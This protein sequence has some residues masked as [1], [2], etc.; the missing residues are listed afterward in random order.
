MKKFG[1]FISICIAGMFAALIIFVIAV[2]YHGIADFIYTGSIPIT[3]AQYEDGYFSERPTFTEF[4]TPTDYG[5]KIAEVYIKLPDGRRFFLPDLTEKDVTEIMKNN[6]N[7][8]NGYDIESRGKDRV[9]YSNSDFSFTYCNGKLI[10]AYF[11]WSPD[12]G[13]SPNKDGPYLSFPIKEKDLIR[14][15]GKPKWRSSSRGTGV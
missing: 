13:F 6:N 2:F 9:H 15:F 5:G 14:V 3:V 7:S 10:W 12:I 4:V 11:D 8:S 1:C